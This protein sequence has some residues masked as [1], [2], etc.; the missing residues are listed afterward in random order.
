MNYPR[1]AGY[2]E[3][4]T[5]KAAAERIEGSG[6]AASIRDRLMALFKAGRVLTCYQAGEE[7]GVSQFAVR[8]R[9]TELGQ[10]G[11]IQKYWKKVGP[12]GKEV[13]AW[14]LVHGKG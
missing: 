10:Q 12:D 6:R 3:E 1:T 11:K 8:P 2:K 4:T 5:S 7:L 9:L 14:G 13:W